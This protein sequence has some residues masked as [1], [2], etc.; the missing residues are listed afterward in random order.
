MN[1]IY[2]ELEQKTFLANVLLTKQYSEKFFYIT[3]KELTKNYYK[4]NIIPIKPGIALAR[5]EFL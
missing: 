2:N 1:N 4:N 3:E 5:Y